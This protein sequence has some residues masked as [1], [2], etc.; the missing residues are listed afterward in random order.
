MIAQ[1][2]NIHDQGQVGDKFSCLAPTLCLFV[3]P[4]GTSPGHFF[5]DKTGQYHAWTRTLRG[6]EIFPVGVGETEMG[7]KGGELGVF[8]L[9]ENP[10]WD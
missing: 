4:G 10:Y 1:I 8:L 3:R 9:Q 7:C 2:K 5:H 6:R